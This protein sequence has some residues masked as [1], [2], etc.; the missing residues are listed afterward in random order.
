M[1]VA[2]WIVNL[3]MAYA[4]L[5]FLFAVVF[6]IRGVEKIDPVAD[7]STVGF[8]AVI[9]FGSVAL[10]PLLLKRWLANQTH[11]PIETNDH[12]NLTRGNRAQEVNR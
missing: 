8:R 5:G 6:V 1:I 4:A 12:R 7:G 11:P 3:A 9:F 10:W 2:Q